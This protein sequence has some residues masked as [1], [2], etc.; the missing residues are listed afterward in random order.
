MH[1]KQAV[2]G[3]VDSQPVL[4]VPGEVFL[5]RK[6]LPATPDYDFN[7]HVMDFA[8]GQF[9]N[10]KEVCGMQASP[11]L[12]A[13][14]DSACMGALAFCCA[15]TLCLHTAGA[16]QPARAAA[17]GRAGHLQAG[18]QLVPCAGRGC[19]LDGALC[20]AVGGLSGR[21]AR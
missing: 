19:Y 12:K 15:S 9:L 3:A 17:A 18:R 21:A 10:V 4:P 14:C 20:G 5:L 11:S 1:G 7:I 13:L 8:P 6:L 2:S 16:L